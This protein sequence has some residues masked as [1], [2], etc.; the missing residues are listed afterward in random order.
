MSATG[1][2]AAP[3]LRKTPLIL[4]T[5]S[6]RLPFLALAASQVGLVPFLAVGTVRLCLA[7]P[8]HFLLGRRLRFAMRLP[9]TGLI[10]GR[11]VSRQAAAVAVLVRPVGRH[12]ALA[13]ALG[14]RTRV[15]MTLD[16]ASTLVY[17]IGIHA[18]STGLR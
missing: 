18:G 11:T 2:L 14:L 13:G 5:L 9:G 12:L 6:P 7:D 8:F 16:V 10:G 17:L 15:V 3:W 1:T 4:I